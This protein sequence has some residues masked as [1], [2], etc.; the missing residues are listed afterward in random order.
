MAITGAGD[1]ATGV[2]VIA[3]G[4]G[5]V[6]TR[7][8]G[9]TTGTTVTGAAIII[10]RARSTAAFGPDRTSR[11]PVASRFRRARSTG[12]GGKALEFLQRARNAG[13]AR[14]LCR[15]KFRVRT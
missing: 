3:I 9:A 1:T 8:G 12:M 7:V 2:G 5:A 6:V 14:R 11:S 13:E 10:E 15:R 4:A